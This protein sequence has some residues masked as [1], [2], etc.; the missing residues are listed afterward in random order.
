ME[1]RGLRTE[2]VLAPLRLHLP[3]VL[4]VVHL[5]LRAHLG[6]LGVLVSPPLRPHQLL[7]A[8]AFGLEDLPPDGRVRAALDTLDLPLQ[9][10]QPLALVRLHH[11]APA[12]LSPPKRSES[13]GR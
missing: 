7:V 9:R 13:D 4:D 5:L 8:R 1:K 2:L 10:L 6:K 12:D 3:P 11:G